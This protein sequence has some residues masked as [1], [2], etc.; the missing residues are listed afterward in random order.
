MSAKMKSSI[1]WVFILGFVLLLAFVAIIALKKAVLT[2]TA[3]LIVGQATG[4]KVELDE[5]DVNPIGGSAHIKNL[6]LFNPPEFNSGLFLS[7][8]EVFTNINIA[9]FFKR[10]LLHLEQLRLNL[11]EITVVRSANGKTNLTALS[12]VENRTEPTR[13]ER[14]RAS[15]ENISFLIDELRLTMRKVNYLDY[16]SGGPEPKQYS[17]D[18]KV[19]EK[20]LKNVT[21]PAAVIGTIIL[22]IAYN[23]NISNLGIEFSGLEE[24]VQ[25]ALA[26]TDVLA[27]Q[28]FGYLMAKK[29][30]KE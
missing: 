8:R 11:D 9:D 24:Q 18:M 30:I 28:G 22:Q 27:R 25:S 15:S 7:V 26:N 3:R 21:D 4:F 17:F 23:T 6:R 16:S 19:N 2:Q 13:T 5:F 1:R 14:E 29:D 20:V 12:S 10:K